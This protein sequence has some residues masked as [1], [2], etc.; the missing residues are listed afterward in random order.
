MQCRPVPWIMRGGGR[1]GKKREQGRGK[2]GRGK[3][4]E[5]R[6]EKVGVNE[7]ECSIADK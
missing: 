4:G 2:E 6:G 1:E 7:G 5:G 3:E